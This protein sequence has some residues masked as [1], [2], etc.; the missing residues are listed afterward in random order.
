MTYEEMLL[1]DRKYLVQKG[2]TVEWF[3]AKRISDAA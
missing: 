3:L 2:F 1:L